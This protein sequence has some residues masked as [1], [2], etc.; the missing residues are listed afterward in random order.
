MQ[1]LSKTDDPEF[2][3]WDLCKTLDVVAQGCNPSRDGWQ[4]QEHRLAAHGQLAWNT[5]PGT[6]VIPRC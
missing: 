6:L 2:R 1:L 3:P 5:V 4:R